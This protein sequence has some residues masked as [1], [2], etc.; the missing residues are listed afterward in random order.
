M[1]HERQMTGI[2]EVLMAGQ[3]RLWLLSI[4][5]IQDILQACILFYCYQSPHS[6]DTEF[7]CFSECIQD[8][9][10]DDRICPLHSE[11]KYMKTGLETSMGI[12]GK[13]SPWLRDYK[14]VI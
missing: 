4:F 5:I 2:G 11:A 1:S 8:Q 12:L 9:V 3:K 14:R 10:W 7:S 6:R 13:E